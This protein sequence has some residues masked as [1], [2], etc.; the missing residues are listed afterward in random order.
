MEGVG[1]TSRLPDPGFWRGKRVLVTGHTG[2][3]GSWLV[4][5]LHSM[6]AQVTGLAQEPDTQPNLFTLAQLDQSV[7]HH[8]VDIRQAASTA[9]AVKHADPEIVLHLA[10]QP[11]V[12]ASYLD[13]LAT[14]SANV[15]GTAHVLDAL[16]HCPDVR[17][18]VVVTT[19]KVYENREWNNPYRENDPLG[20]YDPYS[21][22]K[23]AA[24]V[25][26][27]S[28]RRSFFADKGVAVVT[29]RAGNVIGGG[30]WCADRIIPDAVRAWQV[31]SALSVRRPQS[32]RPWQH[33]IEPLC[34]YLLLAEHA[35]HHA[36]QQDQLD[37]A[38]NFGPNTHESATVREVIQLAQ[39]AYGKGEVQWGDGHEGPHE[40]GLL[41]LDASLARAKL[42]LHSV[43]N[44][45]Q[46]VTM[47]LRWYR[48]LQGG[49]Q[50]RA[51]CERDIA[52]YVAL[53]KQS[54]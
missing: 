53:A 30:D 2:F 16:R 31:G 28:Y 5:W 19:D 9:Q 13:P 25:V 18:I 44:L 4:Q 7:A 49:A 33:V 15:M 50:A 32:V 12:R 23:A 8:V 22:S 45:S 40:A 29:A 48:D 14:F 11:L 24:E 20:G 38:W 54:N 42:G 39:A 51:L 35:W 36:G 34:G 27:S 21:A 17:S 6:G 43:F 47:S 41:M 37:T 46:A 26:T 3:K 10:A 52:A 1:V